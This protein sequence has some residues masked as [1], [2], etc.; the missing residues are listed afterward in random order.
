MNILVTG[1]SSGIGETLVRSLVEAGHRV[2]LMARRADMLNALVED[3]GGESRA[4]AAPGDVGVWED[5]VRVIEAG[6]EA[7]GC[8]DALVNAAGTWVAEPFVDAAP[9]DLQRFVQTD[10]TGALQISRAILPA[11]RKTG[12]RM[13][14]INGLQG[15]IPQRPPVL[16]ATVESAIL[17]LCRSLRWEAASYG[18]QIGLITL[19]AVANAESPEHDPARLRPEDD[20][21]RLSRSDIAE[22]VLFMLTRPPGVNVDELILTP[23]AQKW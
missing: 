7:F 11:L 23:L 17:G 4:L 21:P 20:R 14:H 15:H 3:L 1:S 18:V 13:I 19:G 2:V 9:E 12:G 10:V 6:L 5:C 8:L 16:Y 22:A